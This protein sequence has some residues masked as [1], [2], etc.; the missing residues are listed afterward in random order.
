MIGNTWEPVRLGTK[1]GSG[2]CNMI[3]NRYN[4]GIN[5]WYGRGLKFCSMCHVAV[6]PDFLWC[7]CCHRKLRTTPTSQT[8]NK[9]RNE[10]IDAKRY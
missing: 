1:L 8:R 9:R 2:F 10:I 6:K 7:P 3:C 4:K 5:G